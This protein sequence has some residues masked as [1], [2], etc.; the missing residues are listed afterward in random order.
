MRTELKK[1]IL[2]YMCENEKEFQLINETTKHFS[3]YI[4]DSN[5][6]HLIGGEQVAEFIRKAEKL[7][8]EEGGAY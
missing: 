2:N 7:I 5:G 4:Y 6:N 1:A 8:K 3:P